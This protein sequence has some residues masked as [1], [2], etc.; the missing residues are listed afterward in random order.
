MEEKKKNS[1]KKVA[2]K[3]VVEENSKKKEVVKKGLPTEALVLGIISIV[4]A[5]IPLVNL[6][7]YTLGLIAII[8]A[9]ISLIRNDSVRKS[10]AG[11]ILGILS[12]IIAFVS[13]ILI[14]SIIGVIISSADEAISEVGNGIRNAIDSIFENTETIE[15]EDEENDLFESILD[16]GEIEE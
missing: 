9:I 1:N 16:N 10:V 13:Q 6:A 3:I 7:S 14:I 12:I 5:F 11:L 4:I 8:F 2:E 15:D